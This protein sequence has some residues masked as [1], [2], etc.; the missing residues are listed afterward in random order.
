MQTCFSARSF[1]KSMP[2]D[3]VAVQDKRK[4][5]VSQIRQ[6]ITFQSF[7]A[8]KCEIDDRRVRFRETLCVIGGLRLPLVV[9]RQKTGF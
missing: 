9:E 7:L 4:V 2:N 6:G 5:A 1:S 3:A 8:A